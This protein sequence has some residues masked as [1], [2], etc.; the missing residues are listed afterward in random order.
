MPHSK[1]QRRQ[2]VVYLPPADKY[3]RLP[4]RPLQGQKVL[5]ERALMVSHSPLHLS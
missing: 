4:C 5:N 1:E 3:R 2:Q